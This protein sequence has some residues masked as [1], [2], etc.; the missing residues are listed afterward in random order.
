MKYFDGN[1]YVEVKDHRFSNHPTESL[2]L[3]KRDPPISLRT[4]YQVQI[5]TPIRKNQKFVENNGEL[6][7]K[8]YPKNKQPIIQNQQQ[9][10]KLPNCPSCKQ[11]NR[12]DFNKEYYC[13]NCENINNKQRHQIDKKVLR[14][15]RDFST[16]LKYANKKNKR[17]LDEYG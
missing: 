8:N 7:V 13:R 17:D 9:K 5:E 3:R 2:I 12:L 1:Y 15:G 4:Q 14:Q 6:E 16:I 10:F 11:N